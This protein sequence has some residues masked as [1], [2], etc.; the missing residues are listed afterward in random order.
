MCSN[1]PKIIKTQEDKA[2][3]SEQGG[4]GAVV[5]SDCEAEQTGEESCQRRTAKHTNETSKAFDELVGWYVDLS[6]K[7]P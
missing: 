2:F 6:M 3:L 5:H 1:K 7:E 4:K